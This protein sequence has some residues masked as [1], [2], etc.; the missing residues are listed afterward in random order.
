VIVSSVQDAIGYTEGLSD[1]EEH[2][3]QLTQLLEYLKVEYKKVEAEV[4]L[5]LDEIL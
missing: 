2:H 1:Y 5:P 3:L 4:G